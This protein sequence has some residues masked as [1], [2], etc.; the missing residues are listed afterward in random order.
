[1]RYRK[2]KFDNL[3]AIRRHFENDYLF[4]YLKGKGFEVL[5]IQP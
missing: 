4:D 5:M 2:K 3:G 1:M